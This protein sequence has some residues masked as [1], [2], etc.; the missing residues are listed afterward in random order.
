MKANF[1]TG[2]LSARRKTI[3]LMLG[4]MAYA[5]SR[6]VLVVMMAVIALTSCHD[7]P[8]KQASDRADTAR[9]A[10]TLHKPTA[11]IRVN[12]RYDDRGNLIGFDSTYTSYYSNFRGDTT[13]MDLVKRFDRNFST[14]RSTWFNNRV[15]SFYFSDPLFRDDFMMKR[16]QSNDPHFKD[17]MHRIDSVN[18]RFYEDQKPEDRQSNGRI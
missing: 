8:G 6:I 16:L 1:L 2:G 10:D 3:D 5:S 14:G 12:R 13:K 17:M 11:D 7:K 9:R 18:G 15:N 4:S